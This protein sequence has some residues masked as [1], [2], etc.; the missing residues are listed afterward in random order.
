[1]ERTE[2]LDLMGDAE[3]LRH[4]RAPIDEVM[5]TAVKRQHEPPRVVGDLLKAEIAEKQARSI[6]YQLT[7]AKLPLAKD[8][9][10]LRLRRHADQRGAGPRSRRRRLPRPAAQRRAGRRH[11]HR[12]DPPRH[13]HRPRLHPQRRPRP[14]LQRRRSGQPA[15]GRGPRRTGRAG[16]PTTSPASTS[17]SSTSSAICPSPSPAASSCS[18]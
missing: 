12:Q 18:T 11:R 14:L 4:A 2:I 13:R 6:K 3:A 17:S 5:A 10:G 16:S 8:L 15:R 7:I 9:D 1:M